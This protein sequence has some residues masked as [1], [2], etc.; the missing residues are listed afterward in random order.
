M[1]FIG[2]MAGST[3]G[4]IKI[5]RTILVIKYIRAE[6]RHMLHPNSLNNIKIGKNLS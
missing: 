5:I 4:G 3:S 6:L 1:F 2:G